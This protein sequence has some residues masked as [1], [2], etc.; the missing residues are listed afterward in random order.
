MAQLRS[1][2]PS[3]PLRWLAEFPCWERRAEETW[4]H[5][6]IV[7]TS[8]ALISES[9]GVTQ[10]DWQYCS[11]LPSSVCLR[12]K[13]HKWE[14]P[15]WGQNK[16]QTRFQY[17][18]F[19]ESDWISLWSALWPKGAVSV[20]NVTAGCGQG[21]KESLTK[22]TVIP[23]WLNILKSASSEEQQRLS[24]TGENRLH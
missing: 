5:S 1:L 4:G 9:W 19:K 10:K 14:E 15:S 17:Y 7:P 11:Y 22:T 13:R 18:S 8:A 2:E 24:I 16:S 6:Q 12:E 21:D 20:S 3:L 23:G